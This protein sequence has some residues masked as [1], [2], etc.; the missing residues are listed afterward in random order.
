MSAAARL[1]RALGLAIMLT[2][3]GAGFG[4]PRALAADAAAPRL[5]AWL[6]EVTLDGFLS[7]TY[8]YNFNR[9]GTRTNQLRVFDLVDNSFRLELFELVAQRA[10]ANPREAGFRVDVALGS[11]VPRVSSSRGLFRTDSTTTDVDL[12]QAFAS[13]VAPLGSGLRIDLGK[14]ITSH[15]YE[16][17]EG[18]DGWN[19]NATRSILFGFAIPFTHTGA[20][21]TYVFS[22]HLTGAL[23]VVNGWDVAEDNNRSKTVGGQLVLTPVAPV[24]LTLNGMT[25]PE[26]ANDDSDARTLFDATAIWNLADRVTLGANGDW[27]S[28]RGAVVAG[29][30][31]RWDGYA[32]YARAAHGNLALSLRAESFDDHDGARTGTAQRLTEFTVTPEARLTQH[33]LVRADLRVDRSDRSV[34]EKRL[35]TTKTQ[36]TL[37]LN[38]LYS[39]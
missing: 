18:Y 16:V 9:P 14:F 12:Q 5:P 11:S 3:A 24:T 8:S 30:T 19:D 21:A 25:G 22:K 10:V 35:G 32:G 38:L 34:F 36:P 15:G 6:D 39:F 1:I 27:G 31:A 17:I 28:E 26:R 7:T 37:L 2:I 33:L 23:M 29:E 20:R 13:Y 4:P